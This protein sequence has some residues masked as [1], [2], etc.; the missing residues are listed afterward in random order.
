[1]RYLLIRFVFVVCLSIG[2]VALS[3]SPSARKADNRESHAIPRVWDE[4]E[5]GSL[6]VPLANPQ[7]SAV[8][9]S[10]EYYYRIPVRPIYKSYPVYAPGREP[11]GYKEW[12]KKQEPQPAF[13]E[14]KLQTMEDWVGAGSEVFHAPT[15]YDE[16]ITVED[17]GNPLW[18]KHTSV[19]IAKDGT[20]PTMRYVIREKGKVELGNFS[21]AMCHTR[22][23]SDGSTIFGAQGNFPFDRA[24]GFTYRNR[25][26]GAVQARRRL[27]RALFDAPWVVPDPMARIESMSVE[28]IASA[29]DEIPLGVMARFGASVFYPVAVSDIIGVKDRKYLDHTGLVR[30][31]ST[32]DLMRYAAINQGAGDLAS[33]KGFI[34]IAVLF[35]RLPEPTEMGPLTRYSDAQLYALAQ[36]IYSLKAPQNPNSFGKLATI[37]KKVFNREGCAAC[38]APPLYTNNKLAPSE[39]FKTRED[40]EQDV[41]PISIGTDPGLACKTR[42]GTGYYKVPSLLGVWYRGPFEHSGSVATLEDWFDPNRLKEDYVP[43]GFRGY[44]VRARAVKGHEFGLRL[45]QSDRQALIAFLKTL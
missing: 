11:Q 16:L 22:V 42:R 5:I 4:R 15:F 7:A 23:T 2:A 9:V 37:G 29:H 30:N 8:H 40:Q 31:R 33:F 27:E 39:G 26:M 20:A 36:Y 34:P 24:T 44:K 12:L 43:T 17:A 18:Y 45:S 25:A 14:S 21:C 13:D 6:E 19:P 35:Q 38:H 28:E 10:S 3:V 41:L 1:M 32:G